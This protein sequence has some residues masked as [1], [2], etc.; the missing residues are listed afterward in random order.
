LGVIKMTSNKEVITGG[1]FKR[2]ITG[3]YS[4]FLLEYEN[5]NQLNAASLSDSGASGT[6]ILRTMG[7]AA[8]SLV[9]AK[10]DGIGG[11]SKR[12]GN[13]AVLGARGNSGVVLSQML[14]GIARGLAGKHEASSSVFGK[15]FQYGILYAQRAIPDEEERPIITVA[16]AVAKGAY[17]AVRANLPI[18]EILAAAI[19]AGTTAME[20]VAAKAHFVDAGGKALLV[21]LEGCLKGLDGNFVSP[22]LSFSSGF[23][24]DH[25]VPNPKND[26][27]RS[28][29][30]TVSAYESKA[31]AYDVERV[32]NQLGSLVVVRKKG[33]Q[34]RLHLHT[35]HPG[36][37]IEQA[38]GWGD[39]HA[40]AID[41]IAD[42][43]AA[44][45]L[46]G[47]AA[48]VAVLAMAADEAV[49]EELQELGAT[50][51]IKNGAG[52]SP[53][54]GDFVN[55]VHSDLAEKYIFLPNSTGLNLV[56][57]QVKRILGERIEILATGNEAEQLKALRV[58]QEAQPFVDA[59]KSM[60]AALIS[61]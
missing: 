23:K 43:H 14:R 44:A 28:Y 10:D 41:N 46:D 51:I 19:T 32:L 47:V 22:S 60:R 15:A 53:S 21:F 3:A 38:I 17:H 58:Y 9:D 20:S 1:D 50:V 36:L 24:T 59:V 6:N 42:P 29:C 49:A 33:N 37:V 11:L 39:L 30:V 31:D 26:L 7:A 57:R 52:C 5:L 55:A 8:A 2:M 40:V 16:R 25:E 4:E 13:A 45:P 48:P 61:G 27:V 12:V 35:D 18:S 54:V 56:L 34:M